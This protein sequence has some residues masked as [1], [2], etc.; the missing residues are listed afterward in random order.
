[1]RAARVGLEHEA[2]PAAP[3]R[4]DEDGHQRAA[5]HHAEVT[6]ED[7]GGLGLG[8]LEKLLEELGGGLGRVGAREDA[9]GGHLEHAHA[10]QGLGHVALDDAAGELLHDG[11]LA[12]ARLAG[13]ERGLVAASQ[14]RRDVAGRLVEAV[15]GRELPVFRERGEVALDE[16][17][18]PIG[19]VGACLLLRHACPRRRPRGRWTD[20]PATDGH[21]FKRSVRVTESRSPRNG[22]LRAPDR[23]HH[24][25]PATAGPA[26][27][28]VGRG[29][30]HGGA[31]LPTAPDGTARRP[32]GSASGRR[33][34]RPSRR[35]AEPSLRLQ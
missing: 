9:G 16:R 10:A 19:L 24:V 2:H 31:A 29:H 35:C 15:A 18:P 25:D 27:E 17:K 6:E 1:M 34:G 4:A 32:T 8:L 22:V 23:E 11:G 7:E 30:R 12:D 20:D 21:R 14:E 3:Q 13:E 5:L 33:P 28:C 26:R